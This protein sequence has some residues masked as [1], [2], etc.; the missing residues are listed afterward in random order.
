VESLK[1]YIV[2]G[3][4]SDALIEEMFKKMGW[5]LTDNI[6]DA[7][8]IQFGG[9][10]DVNPALY[11]EHKHSTTH[12]NNERDEREIAIYNQAQELGIACAGICR[13]GQFLHVMNGG[14]LWQDV[15]GHGFT[16]KV[17]TPYSYE[18][19]VSSTH[20]QM[21]RIDS[22]SSPE[23]IILLRA[24]QSKVKESMS[25]KGLNPYVIRSRITTMNWDDIEAI[26]Y[27]STNSL[28]Y[29]PHPEYEGAYNDTCRSL[30]FHFIKNYPLSPGYP[31]D[32]LN[33][34]GL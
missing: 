15:E 33:W 28:C 16:H 34:K 30:Y 8:L 25:S 31:E 20:H 17:R 21:M 4:D 2:Y 1:V 24:N 32:D 6:I 9:G 3:G 26:Y 27:P 23:R 22:N 10:E 7:D 14:S 18:I 13:G 11:K 12:F 5:T 29:Q 19:D